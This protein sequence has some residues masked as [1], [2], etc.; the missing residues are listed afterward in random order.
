M[1]A[2]RFVRSPALEGRGLVHG[3]GKREEEGPVRDGGG[4]KVQPD[5]EVFP[6]AFL[7]Q[8]H[9]NRVF[10]LEDFLPEKGPWSEPGDALITRIPGIA[11]GVF[12]A[13]CLPILLFDPILPAVGA[14]HAG[15]RGTALGVAKMAVQEMEKS[16]GCQP[17]YLIA[18]MG[19][20]I[21]PCCYEVDGPVEEAFAAG[22]IP[23]AEVARRRPGGKWSLDLGRANSWI[24]ERAGVR[25]EN[26][27]FPAACTSCRTD[28]FHSYRRERGGRG[29]QLNFIVLK[30]NG[31]LEKSS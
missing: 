16:L 21:G 20:A 23:W 17:G 9:G 29:K 31:C 11:L 8:V 3:F 10:V 24:L 12:T 27:H 5:Q 25:A 19:P 14:V 1:E 15:W 22:G 4:W 2:A 18:A 13:D 28:L 6:L 7:R 30:G 26:I